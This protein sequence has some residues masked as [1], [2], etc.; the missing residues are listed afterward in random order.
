MRLARMDRW[1]VGR[2]GA[3]GMYYVLI[4][5]WP[6][7]PTIGRLVAQRKD[8]RVI[9]R[10]IAARQVRARMASPP[11]FVLQWSCLL[12]LHNLPSTCGCSPR[13]RYIPRQD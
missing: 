3:D 10:S 6:L 5:P 7:F 2:A 12:S 9:A 13:G 1:R 4:R 11:S 8:D